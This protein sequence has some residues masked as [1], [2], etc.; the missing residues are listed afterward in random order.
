MGRMGTQASRFAHGVKCLVGQEPVTNHDNSITGHIR[1]GWKGSTRAF[2]YSNPT[3]TSRRHHDC[4]NRAPMTRSLLLALALASSALAQPSPE[5]TIRALRARS[6]QAIAR[7]NIDEFA[8]SLDSD[9][10][11]VRGSGVFVGSKKEYVALFEHDFA[12]PHSVTYRRTP[13]KIEV[14]SAAPLAAELGRWAG[15]NPDGTTGYGGTYL[16]MW[17]RTGQGWK[18]RS[19]LFVV[20]SCGK[21]EACKQYAGGKR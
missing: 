21:G 1:A 7:H 5:A 6:N 18:I 15:I 19:E 17:R 10:V 9:F 14:S 13:E 4:Y 2:P 16:A 11:M 8:D 12:D 3:D 20:L